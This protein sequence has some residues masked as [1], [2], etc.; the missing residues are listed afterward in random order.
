MSDITAT[1][2]AAIALAEER[3]SM[4]EGY[5]FL[6]EKCLL[7]AGA[8]LRELRRYDE[9]R[10]ALRASQS[11]AALALAAALNRHGLQG[12]QCYPAPPPEVIAL[13]IRERLLLNVPLLDASAKHEPVAM[14]EPVYASP[15]AER[16]RGAFFAM[17]EQLALL[18]AMSGN[19]ERLYRDYRRSVR[20]VR[21]LQDVLLPELDR[22]LYEIEAQLDELEREEAL[23]ARWRPMVSA[24]TGLS[25]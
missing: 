2:S 25:S 1:R 15:E 17:T 22:D 9:A 4:Q 12:L 14:P 19:L 11:H 3:R 20:R 10:A 21:A 13:D 7:L 23:G 18:A 5:V 8:M 16:C 6:D 24:P